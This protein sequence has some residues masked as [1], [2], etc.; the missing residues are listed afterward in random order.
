M[1]SAVRPVFDD[2]LSFKPN[3]HTL[4]GT[5]Y[6]LA[7]GSQNW[8]IDSPQWSTEHCQW[9]EA[10]G[11]LQAIFLTHRGAIGEVSDFAKHFS[12]PVWIHEQEAYLVHDR[13]VRVETF[14]QDQEIAPG[15]QAIWTPGH[16]PGSSCL[17]WEAHGGVLFSGRHLLPDSKRQPAP[18][19]ISKTFHWPRQLASVEKLKSFTFAAICPGAA[20][21]MLRGQ[22]Y[23]EVAEVA[24]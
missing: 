12:C 19:R 14:G 10:H 4:G 6:F 18:L 8:L 2:L 17:L 22:R 16:S 1:E 20:T 7:G 5:A 21:G 13:A 11:G 9:I 3:R 24:G 15:L 23:L